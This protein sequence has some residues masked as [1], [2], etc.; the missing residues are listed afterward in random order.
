MCK[1]HIWRID[2]P[3]PKQKT[4]TH[5]KNTLKKQNKNTQKT[6]KQTQKQNKRKNTNNRQTKAST[7]PKEINNK[8]ERDFS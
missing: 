7:P 2:P 1:I 8:T 5:Q 3:P 6:T 4:Q